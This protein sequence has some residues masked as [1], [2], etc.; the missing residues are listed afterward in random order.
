MGGQVDHDVLEQYD[1]P[2]YTRAERLAAERL[3]AR[4]HRRLAVER[5]ADSSDSDI[6]LNVHEED[7]GDVEDED[8]DVGN[9]ATNLADALTVVDAGAESDGDKKA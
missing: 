5:L 6:E 3:T 1:I 2:G 8:E 7:H 9:V 4:A